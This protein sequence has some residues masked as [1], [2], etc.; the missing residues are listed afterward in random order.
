MNQMQDADM[1]LMQDADMYQ[2]QDAVDDQSLAFNQALT[3]IQTAV[4]DVESL[5]NLQSL[6]AQYIEI[7]DDIAHG[8]N[9]L[10]NYDKRCLKNR[11]DCVGE[12][13][14][15][16]REELREGR[17]KFTFNSMRRRRE[18]RLNGNGVTTGD[19]SSSLANNVVGVQGGSKGNDGA[20]A[21]PCDK[22]S[23]SENQV[24]IQG[25]RSKKVVLGPKEIAGKQVKLD[26]LSECE[27]YL[28]G[29]AATL[30]MTNLSYCNIY[31]GPV[32]SSAF[33][34]CCSECSFYI[35][36]HQL[37][38]HE[39]TEC[40]VY[41]DTITGTIIE[42]CTEMVFTPYNLEYPTLK[43]ELK[44]IGTS[45][46]YMQEKSSHEKIQDFKWLRRDKPSPNW[47]MLIAFPSTV[48]LDD[49]FAASPLETD[50]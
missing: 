42:D 28:F 44:E 19:N 50:L 11:G 5:I 12:V 45:L 46:E 35:I 15:K 27:I 43:A 6:H 2:M 40:T 31:T 34:N 23:I 14:E 30:R 17:R 18:G 7:Q 47:S 13:I 20:T 48:T 38:F 33:I 10:T 9:Q 36:A 3:T 39:S 21:G 26:H 29:S 16:R 8:N 24:V 49:L 22:T 32:R 41:C 37:R 1:N 25:K 4:R